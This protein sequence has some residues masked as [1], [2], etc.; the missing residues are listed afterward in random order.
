MKSD[1]D[2]NPEHRKLSEVA[3]NYYVLGEWKKRKNSVVYIIKS[4]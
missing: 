2:V 1:S 4:R 3:V